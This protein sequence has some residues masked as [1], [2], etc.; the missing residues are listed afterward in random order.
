MLEA[1]ADALLFLVHIEHNHVNFLADLE[2]FRRM[3]DAAPAHVCDVEEAVNAIQLDEGA[4]IRDVLDRALADVA[5]HHF[6]Q[7]L[8]AFFVALLLDQFTARQHDVLPLLID[9]DNLEFVGVVDKLREVSGRDDVNLRRG[10]KR[11][12]A[13]VD[14][15]AAFDDRLDLAQDRAAF[16]A[17]GEDA[18]PIL[19]ELGLFVRELDRAVLVFE[20]F[21]QDINYVANL[22]RVGIHKLIGGDDAFAFVTDVHQNFLGAD[23]D[24]CAFDYFADGKTHGA[25]LHGF[26]HCEHNCSISGLTAGDLVVRG[27]G[28]RRLHCLTTDA[29]VATEG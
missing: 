17:N 13:D 29:A 10:Q 9:F 1:E 12:D 20:F 15:Q 14:D 6:S 3:I 26:F 2:K 7:Q 25:L 19:F 11:L 28:L 22:E 21:D 4:E 27:N 18:L 16:V 24:D 23:F 8:G 5:R